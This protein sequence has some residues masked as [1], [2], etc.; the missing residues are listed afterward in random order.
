MLHIS[1]AVSDAFD[2]CIMRLVETPEGVGFSI[3][4]PRLVETPPPEG[5]YWRTRHESRSE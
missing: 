1:R 5:G 2:G 4:P 3:A